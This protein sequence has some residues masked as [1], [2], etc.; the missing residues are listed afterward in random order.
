MTNYRQEG[1]SHDRIGEGGTVADRGEEQQDTM[2]TNKACTLAT[3]L[4]ERICSRANLNQAYKR[5]RA[6]KGVPGVDGMTASDFKGT[7]SA[8]KEQ[9]VQ[10]LLD[11]SYQPQA[12]K[13]VK[14]PKPNGGERQLGIP[15]VSDRVVQQAILQVLQPTF[16]SGFSESSYGFRPKRSAHDALK[17]ASQYVADG[18]IWVVDMDLEKFFDRVNHDIYSARPQIAR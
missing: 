8:Y 14:I 17:A 16:D 10:S 7:S 18:K 12:V 13:G 6:N 4:M 15:T 2:A 3:D 1:V 5:V 9:W 11:G